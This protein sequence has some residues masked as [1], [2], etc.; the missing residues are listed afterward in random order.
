MGMGQQIIVQKYGGTSVATTEAIQHVA[1]QVVAAKRQGYAVVVVVSAMGHTTDRLQEMA[2]R[3]TSHPSP[4]ELDV[5]LVTGEQVTIA[6]LAMAIQS[7]GEAA[8]SFTGAH[9]GILTNDVHSNARILEIRPQRIRKA[10]AGGAIVVAAGFQGTTADHEVTTLG[11]G[12]SDTTAVA[13]AAAL[14]AERCEIYTDVDGVYSAD[15]R[16]VL[17]A[18]RL[19]QI[20]SDEVQALAWHGAQ[21]LKAEAVELARSNG[22]SLLVRSSCGG[23]GSTSIRP[24]GSADAYVPRRPAVAAAVGR[25][26]LLRVTSEGALSWSVRQEIFSALARF[27]L[28][29]GSFSG[30]GDSIDLFISSQEIPDPAVFCR[31]LRQR[32]RDAVRVSERLGAVTLVGFGLGS[33][34]WSC[35]EALQ[36]LE[37]LGVAVAG[38]FTTRESITFILPVPQVDECTRAM[39]LAFIG[40]AAPPGRSDRL[41][42]ATGLPPCDVGCSALKQKESANEVHKVRP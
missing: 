10:L 39:H 42:D 23:N 1:R 30:P 11:R 6:L 21:V 24:D 7:L 3:I 9:C 17:D 2:T 40:A 35:L 14:G 16:V 15:P 25:K 37:S 18:R 20:S 27:D 22:V 38:S 33:R 5:L 12:G 32:F 36:I 28:V 8:V 41:H 34:P 31:D 19:G 29:F 26:D 13:L 4:R